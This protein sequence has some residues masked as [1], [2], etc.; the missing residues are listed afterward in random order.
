MLQTLAAVVMAIALVFCMWRGAHP[1]P[2][3]PWEFEGVVTDRP[4][5]M[6]IAGVEM[7]LE[8]GQGDK[9]IAHTDADGVIR[10]RRCSN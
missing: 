2:P 8:T 1:P 5:Q 4:T 6:P 7:G 9:H 10:I 3:P